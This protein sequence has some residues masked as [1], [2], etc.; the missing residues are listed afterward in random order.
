MPAALGGTLNPPGLA[1]PGQLQTA[2]KAKPY[3]LR[4]RERRAVCQGTREGRQFA[5]N[6]RFA[7]AEC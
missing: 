5:V 3:R 2:E 6:C 4:D 7:R 1:E